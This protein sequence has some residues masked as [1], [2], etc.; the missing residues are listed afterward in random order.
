MKIQFS[1]ISLWLLAGLWATVS[2]AAPNAVQERLVTLTATVTVSNTGDTA[3]KAYGHR[4]TVPADDHAQQ[5]LLRI[6]YP[7]EDSYT[8]RPHDNGV[9]NYLK[10]KWD[11]PPRSQL[12]RQI[13][14]RLR[15]SPFDHQ[16]VPIQKSTKGNTDFLAPSDY[17][18]SNSSEIQSLAGQIKRTYAAPKDQ[19]LAAYDYPQKR[20]RYIRMDNKGAVFALANGV[21]DCT[22]YAAIFIGVARAL[23]IPARMTS[24][25]N[26]ASSRSFDAPNHHAAEVYIDGAW[27]PVDPN[28][29]LEPALGY[30]FGTG[31]ANKVILKRGDSWVW[32]NSIPGT[33]KTYRDQHV[34]VDTRWSVSVSP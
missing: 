12:V 29:A 1:R 30:G 14:F 19:L 16:R 6:D 9:D 31:A 8:A 25:F 33:S 13:S 23:G 10:F 26:F 18:E 28:L 5:R 27:V 24:E 22:E 21:G 11:I 7:Y 32:S 15:L 17:V 20:L 34:A 3:L 4:L 2:F